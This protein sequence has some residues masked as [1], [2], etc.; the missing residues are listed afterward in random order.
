MKYCSGW[1]TTGSWILKQ[2]GIRSITLA[3][4]IG[5]TRVLN[6]NPRRFAGGLNYV[7]Y[8]GNISGIRAGH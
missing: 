3:L 6:K 4:R 8:A 2:T 7:S 5:A 1:W